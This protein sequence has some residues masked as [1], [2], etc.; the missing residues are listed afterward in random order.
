[1]QIIYH[2]E[3]EK[4]DE[5]YNKYQAVN[6]IA[7]RARALNAKGLETGMGSRRK[8]VTVATNELADGAIQ[9][10]KSQAEER[11]KSIVDMFAGLM[12]DDEEWGEGIFEPEV[13]AME[14]ELEVEQEEGL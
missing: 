14:D 9:Y 5:T 10:E 3:M 4:E 12:E 8:L 7:Q 2:D 6:A 11:A 1:M 13:I